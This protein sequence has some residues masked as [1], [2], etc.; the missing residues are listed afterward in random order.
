MDSSG[1]RPRHDGL[2]H[3]TL[4]P[5][6]L[7]CPF[8]PFSPKRLPSELHASPAHSPPCAILQYAELSSGMR[9]FILMVDADILYSYL[10]CTCSCAVSP[11][12]LSTLDL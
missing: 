1:Q 3:S 6:P 7:Y 5:S 12:N 10:L 11:S 9:A 2:C 8:S 4:L